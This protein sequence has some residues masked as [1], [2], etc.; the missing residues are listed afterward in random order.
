MPQ[1]AETLE[2]LFSRRRF[3]IRHG[4]ERVNSLLH[5]LGNP[6]DAFKT[7][8][9]VGTNGKGSTSAF[10]S[11]ILSEAGYS[12][13]LFTSPHLVHFRERF[14]I[15]GVEPGDERIMPLLDFVHGNS[16]GRDDLF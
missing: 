13:A 10:L 1:Y 7:I 5:H 11:S 14:R 8:H 4:L 9:V 15:N 16:F 6:Q 2:K 3:G 12:T